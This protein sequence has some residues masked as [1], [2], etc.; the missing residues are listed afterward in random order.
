VSGVHSLI[1]QQ[2][3][4]LRSQI[5][6]LE[7]EDQG[8]KI[9]QMVADALAQVTRPASAKVASQISAEL[10]AVLLDMNF[11]QASI[12]TAISQLSQQGRFE[13]LFAKDAAIEPQLAALVEVLL[14]QVTDCDSSKMSSASASAS[15]SVARQTHVRLEGEEEQKEH[16][17][18]DD[19]IFLPCEVCDT[20][21]PST[22]L[23]AHQV[24]CSRTHNQSRKVGGSRA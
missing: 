24:K 21:V 6:K 1:A 19:R 8:E 13:R 3:E 5:K 17:S 10:H 15:V 22:Q 11:S 18:N 23:G 7:Q 9:Q 14:Q 4:L 16:I 2:N 12:E 20:L